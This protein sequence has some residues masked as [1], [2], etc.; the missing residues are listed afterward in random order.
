MPTPDPAH[1]DF[2]HHCQQTDDAE[3]VARN[4]AAFGHL[5][6]SRY[7][8]LYPERRRLAILK[9]WNGLVRIPIQRQRHHADL[10]PRPAPAAQHLK[11]R[12]SP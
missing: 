2:E 8:P 12:G 5:A 11:K 4:I 6:N 10:W 3:A 9:I 1:P 7:L